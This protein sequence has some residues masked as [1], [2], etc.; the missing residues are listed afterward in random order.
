MHASCSSEKN[1]DFK[2]L[3]SKAKIQSYY[4]LSQYEDLND[5]LMRKCFGCLF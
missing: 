5:S 1:V 4:C 2:A 3:E